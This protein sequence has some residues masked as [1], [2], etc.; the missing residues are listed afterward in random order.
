MLRCLDVMSLTQAQ[1]GGCCCKDDLLCRAGDDRGAGA[2][3]KADDCLPTQERN[4]NSSMD[5]VI[6]DELRLYDRINS[7]KIRHVCCER[8]ELL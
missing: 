5:E 6:I 8:K 4:R 7:T 2:D 3:W 1:V